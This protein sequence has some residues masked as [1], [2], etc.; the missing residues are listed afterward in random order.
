MHCALF[1]IV[2]WAANLTG[3]ASTSEAFNSSSTAHGGHPS[4]A[5]AQ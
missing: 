3:N 4:P 1:L 2:S 5:L